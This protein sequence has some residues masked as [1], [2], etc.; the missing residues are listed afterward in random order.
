MFTPVFDILLIIR[1]AARIGRYECYN[2]VSLILSITIVITKETS[3][4]ANKCNIPIND[5]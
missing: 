3:K 4:N 5:Q 1:N 2:Y